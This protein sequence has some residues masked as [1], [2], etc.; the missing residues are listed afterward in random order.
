[1]RRGEWRVLTPLACL[2]AD[3]GEGDE[4]EEGR[5]WCWS[6]KLR[7]WYVDVG[8]WRGDALG[9]PPLLLLL[10]LVLL[11]VVV[12]LVLVVLVEEGELLAPGG[13]EGS[14]RLA[15]WICWRTC[16]TRQNKGETHQSPRCCC[17]TS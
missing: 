1:M 12:L 7:H 13:T 6:S 16:N 15:M 10:L 8:L 11:V 14:G 4:E 3:R 9:A 17:S 5:K 2:A